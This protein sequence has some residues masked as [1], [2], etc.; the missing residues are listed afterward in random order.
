MDIFRELNIY[1]SFQPKLSKCYREVMI[2]NV[3][4]RV[5]LPKKIVVIKKKSSPFSLSPVM[6]LAINM[7]KLM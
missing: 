7:N 4:D 2:D 6:L 3:G 1:T 5:M